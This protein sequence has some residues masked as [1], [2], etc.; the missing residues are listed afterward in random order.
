MFNPN[1][2][3]LGPTSFAIL[4]R[5]PCIKHIKKSHTMIF[6]ESEH[7]NLPSVP[8]R[9]TTRPEVVPNRMPCMKLTA[10]TG[11]AKAPQK[12]IRTC[13][14]IWVVRSLQLWCF[15]YLEWSWESVTFHNMYP[16]SPSFPILIEIVVVRFMRYRT[17]STRWCLED[18]QQMHTKVWTGFDWSANALNKR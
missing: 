3:I 7:V 13:V 5:A 9:I 6:D 18:W 16:T 4:R 11:N 2:S 17:F 1:D 10:W 12:L 8:T 15:W 14:V